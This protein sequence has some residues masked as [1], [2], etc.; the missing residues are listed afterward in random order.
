MS[1]LHVLSVVLVPK[2]KKKATK[3]LESTFWELNFLLGIIERIQ[4][5]YLCDCV[6]GA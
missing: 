5:A 1:Y 4:K 6:G 2:K 3:Y